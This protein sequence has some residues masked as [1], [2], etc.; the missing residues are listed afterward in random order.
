[1][2]LLLRNPYVPIVIF[3]MAEVLFLCTYAANGVAVSLGAQT[4]SGL[5]W[6]WVMA[7]WVNEHSHR[8]GKVPSYDFGLLLIILYP[9]SVLWYCFWLYRWRGV[10]VMLLLVLLWSVPQ[11]ASQIVWAR[12]P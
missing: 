9:F 4:L 5:G 1:M 10:L 3:A 2:A 6:T 11:I 8:R 7:C 12:Q